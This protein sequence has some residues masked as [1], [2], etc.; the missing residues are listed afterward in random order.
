M[1]IY[2]LFIFIRKEI[3]QEMLHTYSISV[4]NIANSERLIDGSRNGTKIISFWMFTEPTECENIKNGFPRL[5]VFVHF[6]HQLLLLYAVVENN[7]VIYTIRA[8]GTILER[9]VLFISNFVSLHN[10]ALP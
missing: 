3:K 1:R 2:Y 6:T 8:V 10:E 5:C 7:I 4:L 9:Q